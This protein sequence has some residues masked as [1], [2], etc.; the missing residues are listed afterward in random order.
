[1]KTKVKVTKEKTT[2]EKTNL[3][4]N[5][6]FM[7]NEVIENGILKNEFIIL[8]YYINISGLSPTDVKKRIDEC[9]KENYEDNPYIKQIFLGIN[10][11][12]RVECIYRKFI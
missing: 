11:D 4:P 12:S 5:I 10:D 7:T 1:M 6:H 9:K 8:V 2:K 3:F